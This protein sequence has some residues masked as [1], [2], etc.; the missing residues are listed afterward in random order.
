[1]TPMYYTILDFVPEWKEWTGI[2]ETPPHV[3]HVRVDVQTTA[4]L[5]SCHD[6]S[7]TETIN[8]QQIRIFISKSLQRPNSSSRER[9][10]IQSTGSKK[11][12]LLQFQ[13][14]TTAPLVHFYWFHAV[15]NAAT[16]T[17]LAANKKGKSDDLA[18]TAC[19]LLWFDE[20]SLGA[21]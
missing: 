9:R 3:T 21:K 20:W 1:M 15:T 13:N 19:W 7:M 10:L 16:G 17:N 11:S 14:S 8:V 5:P 2:M 12:I 4:C 18:L 6:L